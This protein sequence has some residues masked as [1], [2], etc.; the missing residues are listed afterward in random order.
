MA[1]SQSSRL[2]TSIAW[3]HRAIPRR[4][5][6]SRA[7]PQ[8][9]CVLAP[10][11][12]ASRSRRPSAPPWPLNRLSRV[13]ARRV[14][15][16]L[17][18]LMALFAAVAIS[19]MRVARQPPGYVG[20]VRNGGPLD[21][22]NIRQI[23]MPGQRL[24][25]IGLFSEAPHEYPSFRALRQ[26]RITSTTPADA[27][28]VPTRDGVQVGI[29]GVAY[30]R[31]VGESDLSLLRRFDLT[32]GTR[33][34]DGRYAWQDDDGFAAM[35]DA[36][37]RPVLVNNV[38]REVG[39]FPCADLVASCSLVRRTPDRHDP[40]ATIETIQDHINATLEVDLAHTLGAAFFRGFRFRLV[41]ITLPR[42]VQA[43]VDT[44]QAQFAGISGARAQARQARYQAKRNELLGS[45]YNAS[46][47]LAR[48][49]AI[50]AAPKG[51][52][53]IIGSG[54][55]PPQVLVGK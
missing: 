49:D 46:P 44:A 28:S 21:N 23:L 55:D 31:F 1:P 54:S 27:V 38:R 25:W 15:T 41:G 8:S 2:R 13:A 14:A 33:R 22:R 26:L 36:V 6:R 39:S 47:A 32:V 51:A 48:I 43:A 40:N 45:S 10:P 29:E 11:F 9:P 24:T 30:F 3:R 5:R 52:T 50:R 53:I 4:S 12:A 19:G 18:A 7:G 17:L 16:L 37:V 35:L 34:F 42:N 20:V